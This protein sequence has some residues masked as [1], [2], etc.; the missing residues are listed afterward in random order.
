[1]AGV[2]RD[3]IKELERVSL[4]ERP[5]A[6]SSATDVAATAASNDPFAGLQPEEIA[7]FKQFQEFQQFQKFQRMADLNQQMLLSSQTAVQQMA[8]Q[9]QRTGQPLS[10]ITSPRL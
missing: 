8:L 9:E 1:M 3:R 10:L 6:N 7:L 5:T 4:A 2:E